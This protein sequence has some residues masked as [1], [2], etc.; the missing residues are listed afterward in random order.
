MSI[1][2]YITMDYITA[3]FYYILATVFEFLLVTAL[4][5]VF[6]CAYQEKYRTL[7]WQVGGLRGW[8]S[9]PHSRVYDYANY[10]EPPPIPLIWDETYARN[11][12]VN[13]KC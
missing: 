6:A 9:D 10:R 2:K 8:N 12:L 1:V 4:I 7:L 13:I 11:T 5:A 3:R